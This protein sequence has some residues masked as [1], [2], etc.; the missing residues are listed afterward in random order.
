MN[1]KKL[2]TNIIDTLAVAS[3]Q[4]K[5]MEEIVKE[6]LLILPELQRHIPPLSM[7]EYAQL[8]INLIND[9]CRDALIVWIDR[10]NDKQKRY[11][12][13]DGHNRYAICTALK[14]DYRIDYLEFDS[15]EYVKYWM[16]NN[17]LGKRNVT[18]EVRS[19]L[20]G[21][22]YQQEKDKSLFKG[23]QFTQIE[24]E[25]TNSPATT[26]KGKNKQKTHE[27]LAEAYKV[28][29]KTIQRDE[30]YMLGLDA[31]VKDDHTMKWKIL[32][33]EIALPKSFIENLSDKSAVELKNI[34]YN[35]SE[36]VAINNEP[37]K[38][39]GLTSS[40]LEN[41]SQ[42]HLEILT[43]TASDTAKTKQLLISEAETPTILPMWTKWEADLLKA[44]K[45]VKK[46]RDMTDLERM[47]AILFQIEQE[48]KS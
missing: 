23:N 35:L 22:Q 10:S 24:S 13:I 16:I 12:L 15:I 41:T 36:K 7:E 32:Q 45:Q 14:I 44:F 3:V 4:S 30:K 33:R 40:G 8:K 9:G 1:S 29:A 47:K 42:I 25:E 34:Y 5:T 46:K 38:V 43:D 19:Y 6:S 21:Q 11:V 18:D 2:K 39:K 37:I 31:L 28:S 17:Q 26:D 20:R 27:R 48:I